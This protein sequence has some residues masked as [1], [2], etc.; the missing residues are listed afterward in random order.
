MRSVA[1]MRAAKIG[2][3]VLSVLLCIL[4]VCLIAYPGFS[5]SVFG[6]ICGI[7]MVL[8][9]IIKLIGYFSR[10]LYRL[11]F[12]FDLA[13]G[14]LFLAL[15]VVFLC[16]PQALMA[17]LCILLGLASLVDG[18]FKIQIAVDA[19]RFGLRTWLLIALEAA[20]TV[21]LGLLL[22][23]RPVQ[24]ARVLMILLGVNLLAEG[25]LNLSTALAVVKIVRNQKPDV[26]DTDGYEVE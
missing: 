12:Q 16:R 17:E 11:A 24:S 18:L 14:L 13:L 21:V 23:F 5:L 4:G 25:I 22:L 8:F 9:G 20:V 15:G 1:P 7:L 3:I 26:I 2:Y 6:V 19:K 10:D